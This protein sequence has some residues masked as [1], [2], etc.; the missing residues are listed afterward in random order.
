[1]QFLI[2]KLKY[3]L[4]LEIIKWLQLFLLILKVSTAF[5]KAVD[6]VNHEIIFSKLE[7]LVNYFLKL[8]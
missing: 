5:L 6:T 3:I 1:M 7:K 4:T 2:F 8:D